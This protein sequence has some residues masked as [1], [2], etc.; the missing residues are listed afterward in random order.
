MTCCCRDCRDSHP[1]CRL[2]CPSLFRVLTC[3]RFQHGIPVTHPPAPSRAPCAGPCCSPWLPSRFPSLGTPIPSV[4][5]AGASR[6]E[7]FPGSVQRPTLQ[8]GRFGPG[9]PQ[10]A[11]CFGNNWCFSTSPVPGEAPLFCPTSPTDATWLVFPERLPAALPA[12]AWLCSAPAPTMDIN[13][14]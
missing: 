14:R 11:S 8:M 5:L 4:F 13:V 12:G 1:P 9:Y 7:G 2:S 6:K 3:A 10:N